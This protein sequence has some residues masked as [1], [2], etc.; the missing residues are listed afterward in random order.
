MSSDLWAYR[1]RPDQFT[2]HPLGVVDGDTF[3]LTVDTG[4]RQRYDARVR[5][6]TV[7]TAEIWGVNESSEEYKRGMRH[8]EA[9]IAWFDEALS[10]H[11]GH[12]PLLIRTERDTG[13]Y[14]RWLAEIE[15]RDT[16]ETLADYLDQRFPD[17]EVSDD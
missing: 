9:V 7:D 3:D 15:R 17:V 8:K 2:D 12:W 6:S 1:A 10:E 13:K 14:G 11:D 16:G 5:S 4:F